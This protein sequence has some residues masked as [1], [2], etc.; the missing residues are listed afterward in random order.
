MRKISDDIELHWVLG[1]LDDAAGGKDMRAWAFFERALERHAPGIV[2]QREHL[3]NTRGLEGAQEWLDRHGLGWAV[4]EHQEPGEVQAKVYYGRARM[5][6]AAAYA[7][8][9]RPRMLTESPTDWRKAREAARR[10]H[11]AEIDAAEEKVWREDRESRGT[12]TSLH[13]AEWVVQYHFNGLNF[14]EIAEWASNV[15]HGRYAWQAIRGAVRAF[16]KK[17][18]LTLR[19]AKRGRPPRRL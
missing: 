17:V 6:D 3:E 4:R 2:L 8:T 9:F 5:K 13:H 10:K 18:D 16:A 1:T 15:G 11:D 19:P 12:S 7:F 14:V